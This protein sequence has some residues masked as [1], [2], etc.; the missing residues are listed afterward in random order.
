MNILPNNLQVILLPQLA[1]CNETIFQASSAAA[2]AAVKSQRQQQEIYEIMKT[3]CL[4][5]FC[6]NGKWERVFF[7]LLPTVFFQPKCYAIK[8]I[9]GI[10]ITK[11]KN[12][13]CLS[14]TDWIHLLSIQFF[15]SVDN[16]CIE[17]ILFYFVF[18]SRLLWWYW[19]G[20]I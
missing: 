13:N 14:C 9:G 19:W 2:A 7:Y 18:P 11:Q 12:R 6:V 17:N 15:N 8:N 16:Q 20:Q 3:L 5:T 10:K 4:F 1:K